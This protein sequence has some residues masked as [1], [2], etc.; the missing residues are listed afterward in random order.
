MKRKRVLLALVL[1]LA[2]SST[3]PEDIPTSVT[4]SVDK[5]TGVVGEEFE[6]TWEATGNYL[7]GV[8][9]DYGDGTPPDSLETQGA[10]QASARRKHSYAQPGTYVATATV[11]ELADQPMSDME[12]VEV[13]GG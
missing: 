3:D 9:L 12:T 1:L 8:I 6:F 2:C 10:L 5:D 13:T 11:E 4:L 7:I